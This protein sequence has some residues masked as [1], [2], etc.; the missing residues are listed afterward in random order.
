M[1]ADAISSLPLV[2]REALAVAFYGQ[3]TYNQTAVILGQPEG[4]IKSRIRAGL[5]RLGSALGDVSIEHEAFVSV[6]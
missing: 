6:R 1:I 2:E 4:T 3:C 5:R